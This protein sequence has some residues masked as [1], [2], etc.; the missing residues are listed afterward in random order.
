MRGVFS[1]PPENRHYA[2]MAD[3]ALSPNT[4]DVVVDFDQED[5][6]LTLTSEA[7]VLQVHASAEDLVRLAGAPTAD[8]SRRQAIAVGTTGLGRVYWCAGEAPDTVHVL[9]GDDDET[10]DLA[11]VIPVATVETIVRLA[12]ERQGA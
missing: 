8:W 4:S 12:A 9:V 3:E 5:D 7:F 2:R 10:W 6:S 11:L 1:Q